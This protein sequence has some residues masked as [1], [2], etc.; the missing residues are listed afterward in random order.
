MHPLSF[1]WTVPCP[2][3]LCCCLDL[4][5]DVGLVY[6]LAHLET[7]SGSQ[8]ETE[9]LGPATSGRLSTLLLQGY[10][11]C[12]ALACSLTS[13]LQLPLWVTASLAA[14]T[15]TPCG[16]SLWSTLGSPMGPVVQIIMACGLPCKPC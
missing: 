4:G 7:P 15:P 2:V 14:I 6:I 12:L 16:I 5:L 9:S 1:V 10:L 13:A 11:Q 8:K 3:L